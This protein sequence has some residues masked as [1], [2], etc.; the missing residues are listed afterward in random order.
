M[1]RPITPSA[2]AVVTGASSG[3]GEAFAR[4][5]AREGLR[6]LL[7]ARRRDRLDRLAGELPTACR[8]VEADLTAS[9]DRDR[10]WS[11]VEELAPPVE[12]L[13]NCAGFGLRGA[14][15]RLGRTPQLQMLQVN[16][17]ALADLALRFLELRPRGGA[18]INVA[19][20]AGFRPVS[21]MATYSA[22]KSFVV[23]FSQ[24]LAE[25]VEP[26]GTRVLA[27]CPGPV[28]TEFNQ[29]AG[30]PAA[31]LLRRPFEISA[32]QVA[33]EGLAALERGDRLWVPGLGMRLAMRCLA[34]VPHRLSLR[35]TARAWRSGRDG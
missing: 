26:R 23:S 10:L 12:L 18:I 8:V 9:E 1:K 32:E 6:L 33:A 21:F 11:A 17:V 31:G 5:L 16:V 14:A 34:L 28:P 7:T 27:L 25:E 4:R 29:V 15:A 20:V 24:A 19:S 30:L 35:A 3:I 22:S 2:W 13:V